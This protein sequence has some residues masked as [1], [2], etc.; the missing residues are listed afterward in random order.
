MGSKDSRTLSLVN[1]D[2]N[3]KES[4]QAPGS[5]PDRTERIQKASRGTPDEMVNAGTGSEGPLPL[6]EGFGGQRLRRSP[7]EVQ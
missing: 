3:K 1:L 7:E 2:P 4:C 6:L 5:V